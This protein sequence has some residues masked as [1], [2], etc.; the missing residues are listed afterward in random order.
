MSNYERTKYNAVLQYFHCRLNGQGMMEAS[1][2]SAQLFWRNHASEKY[3]PLIIRTWARQYL[4]NKTISKSKQGVH[5]KTF[6]L[7]SDEAIALKIIAWFRSQDSQKRDLH[8]LKKYVDEEIIMDEVEQHRTVSLSTLSRFLLNNGFSFKR[9]TKQVY[10]DGHE[11][12]DVVEYRKAFAADMIELRKR[13]DKFDDNDYSIVTPPTLKEGDRKL[14]MVTHDE[15]TFY[16]NDYKVTVWLGQNEHVLRK[17]GL[18]GS[19]MVSEF[20]C[21]CHGSISRVIKACGKDNWWTSEDMTNQLKNEAIDNFEKM[22][23]NRQGLFLFDQSSN[24]AAMPPDALLV[25]KINLHDTR[26]KIHEEETLRKTFFQ[27]PGSVE[28]HPQDFMIE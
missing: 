27:V 22:H 13:M 1:Q 4:A 26:V 14:V 8:M 15:S 2:S 6:S 28:N 23:P 11:R 18:G 21:P 24:H 7:L 20:L 12:E 16:A 25:S 19:L 5:I 10:M 17:K 3:R 9:I